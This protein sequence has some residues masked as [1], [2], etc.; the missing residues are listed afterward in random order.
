MSDHICRTPVTSKDSPGTEIC[1]S[2]DRGVPDKF[3]YL[4]G[5]PMPGTG[6]PLDVKA[7]VDGKLQA[8]FAQIYEEIFPQEDPLAAISP[9]NAFV[10][11]ALLV[12]HAFSP[13]MGRRRRDGVMSDERGLTHQASC[14]LLDTL[15]VVGSKSNGTVKDAQAF[16]CSS[17]PFWLYVLGAPV[18]QVL[19]PVQKDMLI[20]SLVSASLS[21]QVLNLSSN[22]SST[23]ERNAIEK[24]QDG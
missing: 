17:S 12:N 8:I 22:P 11:G 10:A 6:Q 14:L 13:V 2:R 18:R 7:V 3:R 20:T 21:L 16:S 4:P 15:I 23:T 9:S 24:R 19:S 1:L 5:P